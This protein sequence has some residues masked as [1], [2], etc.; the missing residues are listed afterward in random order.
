MIDPFRPDTFYYDFK[1]TSCF[2]NYII[3]FSSGHRRL[4][5][6]GS[7]DSYHIHAFELRVDPG[8][9]TRH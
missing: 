5:M 7:V 1:C 4:G 6:Q 9:A 3:Q 2:E 8:V